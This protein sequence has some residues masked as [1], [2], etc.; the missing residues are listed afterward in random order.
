MIDFQAV[1]SYCLPSL[2]SLVKEWIPGGKFEGVQYV[3]KNPNRS[4]NNPGSFKINCNTGVWKDFSSG[5]TGGD[6]ISFYAFINNFSQKE[7][8]E[9]LQEIYN[10]TPLTIPTIPTIKTENK[11]YPIIPIPQNAPD[12]PKK[13]KNTSISNYYSYYN[14]KNELMLYTCRVINGQRKDVVPLTYCSDG[15]GSSFWKFKSIPGKRPIYG[16]YELEQ[17]KEA[18]VLI[19][20]GEKCRD[21]AV[22]IFRGTKI[23]P[24]SWIGGT[25]GIQKIDWS[26]LKGRNVIFW[27][28][29]D[30]QRDNNDELLPVENQPGMKAMISI[31]NLIKKDIIGAK[32][33]KPPIDKVNGWDIAD[34]NFDYKKAVNFIKENLVEFSTLNFDDRKKETEP[35]IKTEI[36]FQCLGYNSNAGNIQYYYLPN[37]TKKVTA[38]NASSHT[39]MNLLSIAPM[40]FFERSY[41]SKAGPRWTDISN[42][43]MRL[44]E[45]VGLYDPLRVRGR[46]AW[47]DHGRSVLHL[48]NKLVVDGKI[49]RISEVKSHYIYEAEIPTEDDVFMEKILPGSEG[50]KLLEICDLL[51][52]ENYISGKLLSGWL[53]LAPICGSIEWRPHIWI[54][55]ESEVG[56]SW[57]LDNIIYPLLG[58]SVIYAGSNSTEPGLRQTLQ[59]DAFPVCLD[60]IEMESHDDLARVQ[61]IIQ[62][63]RQASS[64]KSALII[65]GTTSGRSMAYH[66][67]SCFLFSSINPK[68][69]QQADENRIT[70]LKLIKRQDYI[71]GNK[72]D[73]LQEKVLSTLT[74][75]YGIMLRSRAIKLIP[76]IRKSAKLMCQTVAKRLKSKRLGDQVGTLLTGA[77][78][79]LSNVELTKEKADYFAD[80]IDDEMEY[81]IKGKTDHDKCLDIILESIVRTDCGNETESIGILIQNA[82][83]KT[84]TEYLDD[85][86]Y[87]NKALKENA[88]STLRKYGISV[89]KDEKIAIATN[90]SMLKKLLRNTPWE[91]GYKIVL[92]R[93]DGVEIKTAVFGSGRR[94]AAIMVP[95]TTIFGSA[96]N[97]K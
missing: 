43:L 35:P 52:W 61:S 22:N 53:F 83:K 62:L 46:G 77:Y 29:A 15:N 10:I 20:E 67:R 18:T 93:L 80:R 78:H 24:I 74:D 86:Y 19:V 96:Q 69:Y 66:I 28:D 54:T 60:E 50:R 73:I 91:G 63:A 49:Q 79:L 58:K 13:F 17:N 45:S 1:N 51:S 81:K 9:K 68:L 88:I 65:K 31:Y 14:S 90:H 37:G 11:T 87:K 3:V 55:G 25:Q 32:I 12:Y 75:E 85:T 94:L 4:D 40:K 57:I 48:G 26:P 64:N 44:C 72:F 42:D 97:E 2:R 95:Y 84:E 23:T 70:L 82:A 39:K 33:I 38:L 30:T 5:D 36:P 7:A 71:D 8:G 16:L 59:N 6:P 76:L 34:S 92:S 47:Y 41:P 89:I 27:P 21:Y 56:K